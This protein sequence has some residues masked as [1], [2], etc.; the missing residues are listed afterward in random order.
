MLM[1]F[2]SMMQTTNVFIIFMYDPKTELTTCKAEFAMFIGLLASGASCGI[3]EGPATD[4]KEVGQG[5]SIEE[6]SVTGLWSR[7][8]HPP[9]IVYGVFY[10]CLP[11]PT[12]AI[13][14][15]SKP[16]HSPPFCLVRGHEKI[17]T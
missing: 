7:L 16:K 10:P 2:P 6:T 17:V 12:L 13:F 15:P 9:T 14:S 4:A 1:T 5:V 11:Y 8:P 3:V